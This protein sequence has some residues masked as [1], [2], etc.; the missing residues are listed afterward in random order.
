MVPRPTLKPCSIR[1]RRSSLTNSFPILI[2]T[3]VSQ[4]LQ[5]QAQSCPR[6]SNQESCPTQLEK[7]KQIKIIADG[8]KALQ[9][10]AS[11]VAG[12]AYLAE[13]KN[14]QILS[15]LALSTDDQTRLVGQHAGTNFKENP[16]PCGLDIKDLTGNIL[17]IMDKPLAKQA[18]F[19]LMDQLFQSETGAFQVQ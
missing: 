4:Q 13:G 2:Y 6:Q 9:L 18:K 7:W 8:I 5:T 19:L 3:D 10:L 16:M 12:V 14:I 11:S 1:T 15:L 17:A